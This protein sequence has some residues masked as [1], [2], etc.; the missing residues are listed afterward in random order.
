[1]AVAAAGGGNEPLLGIEDPLRCVRVG[2][3][4][5]VDRRA[6]GTPQDLG[7]LDAV[8]WY[9][10]GDRSM[11]QHLIDEQVH[12]RLARSA[13]TFAVR[14]WRCASARTCHICQVERLSSITAR[15]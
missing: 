9:D 4:H 15:M 6:G 8:A 10:K 2:A 1:L 14:I 7:F 3:G 13:G 5:G 11:I 12:Q